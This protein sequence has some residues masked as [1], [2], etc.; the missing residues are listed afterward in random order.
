M[1]LHQ[2]RFLAKNKFKPS[3]PELQLA[4]SINTDVTP[5]PIYLDC[6]QS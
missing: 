5:E 3:H 4:N 6:Y 2:F 1:Q